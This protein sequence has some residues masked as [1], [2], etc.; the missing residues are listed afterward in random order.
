MARGM[1]RA[2]RLRP[3]NSTK[4]ILDTEGGMVAGLNAVT[5]VAVGVEVQN[6]SATSNE[7]PRGGKVSWVYYSVYVFTDDSGA[8]APIVNMYW[9]KNVGGVSTLPTTGNTGTSDLKRFIIHEE[10]GL[11]G[12]KND[13]VPMVVKG[14]LKIPPSKQKFGLNDKIQLVINNESAN[15][16]FCAKH[17]YKVFY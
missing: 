17:I 4:N 1:G 3:V 16:D 15:G 8:A 2:L 7:V 14:V 9:W 6:Y 10:K 5:D 11:A 12:N 13:G